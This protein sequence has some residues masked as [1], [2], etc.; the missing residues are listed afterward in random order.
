[1]S[2]ERQQQAFGLVVK[3]YETGASHDD[4]RSAFK[5]FT[6]QKVGTFND[7]LW[8]LSMNRHHPRLGDSIAHRA[9]PN[10][11]VPPLAIVVSS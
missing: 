11:G 3:R 7:R 1:M 8:G 10:R 2:L 6:P 5:H 9:I 4:V